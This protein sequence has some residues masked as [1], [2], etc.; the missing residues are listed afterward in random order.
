MKT[1]FLGLGRMGS[2]MAR[3]I[4]VNKLPL[5]VYNRHPEKS[6]PFGQLGAKVHT[7]LDSAL[8]DAELIFTM[9]SDDGALGE[10]INLKSLS[11]TAP[12]CI[13]VSMSTVSIGFLAELL[14]LT[15]ELHRTLCCCPV[16]GR[17]QAAANGTLQLCLAGPREA[18][19]KIENYLLPMGRVWDFGQDPLGAMAVKLSGNFMIASLLEVLSEAFS[20]VESLNADPRAF[21][22]LMSTTLFAAPAVR[23]YGELILAGAFEE[24]GFAAKL[25]RKDIGLIKDAASKSHNPMPLASL[26]EDKFLRILA[27]GWGEKDWSI[28]SRL[29]RED[30]GLG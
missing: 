30:A 18:T 23:T 24:A 4:L 8:L 14:K 19:K 29:Q 6:Y 7:E 12:N 16:F 20:L 10:L 5:E 13:H 26:L 9:V 21:F 15:G 27:R 22:Q 3:R 2:A 28:I 17:P 25:G 1:V 11:L